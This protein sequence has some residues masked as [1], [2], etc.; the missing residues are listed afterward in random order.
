MVLWF[1]P[2]VGEFVCVG[3]D[4]VTGWIDGEPMSEDNRHG[5]EMQN[6][7]ERMR[8]KQVYL[9]RNVSHDLSLI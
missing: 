4:I 5:A 8:S 2:C 1:W 7:Q 3:C 9:I 6:E